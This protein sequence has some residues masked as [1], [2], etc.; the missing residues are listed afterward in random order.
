MEKITAHSNM[1][2]VEKKLMYVYPKGKGKYGSEVFSYRYDCQ[3][4]RMSGEA[5]AYSGPFGQ[6]KKVWSGSAGEQIWGHMVPNAVNPSE[7]G[8]KA[9]ERLYAG[10]CRDVSAW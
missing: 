2:W 9:M 7:V 8:K 4:K 1:K 5:E 6:G 3:T 10:L